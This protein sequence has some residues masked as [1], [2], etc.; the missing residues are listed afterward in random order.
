MIKFKP[1][2]IS[3]LNQLSDA[4]CHSGNVLGERLQVSRTAIWKKIQNL[5]DIGVPIERLPNQGYRLMMPITLLNEEKIRAQLSL[6]QFK[7]PID[8][9]LFA[10]IDSTNRQLKEIPHHGAITICCA[11]TQ[12]AGRGRFGRQ[13]HSPFGENIYGSIRW[14]FDCDLSRLSGLSLVVSMAIVDTL[15]DMGIHDFIKIKW[16]NDILWDHK[17]LCGSLIEVVAESNS[18]LDVIIGI[19]LNV[20]STTTHLP[21]GIEKPWCSLLD[22]TGRYLDRNVLIGNLITHLNQHLQTF[23][24]YGFTAFLSNWHNYDYL[25]GASIAISQPTG[26]LHGIAC[27][28]NADGQLILIDEMNVTHCLSSGDTSL[29]AMDFSKTV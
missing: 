22:I 18:S 27:G 15:N 26:V 16:P 17:K 12:T 24:E 1:T 13:W 10:S 3:L 19:G 21:P 7:M 2:Q 29:H 14:H 25:Y 6:R 5:I 9:D 8:F 20:N 28:V 4:A 23:I 11:E